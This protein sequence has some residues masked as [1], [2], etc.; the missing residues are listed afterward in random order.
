MLKWDAPEVVNGVTTYWDDTDIATAYLLP[1]TARFRLDDEGNPVFKFMKYKF[2]IDRADGKKGGGF[3]VCDVAF[4]VTDA[5][6]EALREPLQERVEARWRQAGHE[7]GA[8]AVRFGELNYLR[9]T[10]SVT[11]LDSGGALVEKIHNPASPSLYGDMILPITV[12]LSPEGATLLESALQEKGGIVQVA[13]DIWTPVK[14]PPVTAHVWFTAS[15]FSTFHQHID[16]EENFCSEDDYTETITDL[17]MQSDSGGVTIDPGTVTDQKIIGAVTDWAW[18]ALADAT[19]RM[20]LGD[21]P[22]QNPEEIRKLYTEQD[23]ENID[24]TVMTTRLA[25]FS[26]TFTQGQVMEWNP[27]PRGTIP[28]ITSMKGPDG[29]P[30]KWEDFATT[31]DLDD[32]FFRTMTVKTHVNADFEKLPLHSVEVKIEYDNAG[33]R[34]VEEYA[35]TGPDEI[36]TFTSFVANNDRR[37]TYTY[38]VNYKGEAQTFTSEPKVV[39]DPSL[40]INVG[41]IGILNLDIK[42]G[43]LNFDQVKSA[44]VELWYEDNGVPRMETAVTLDREHPTAN[45]TKV[46]F[47]PRRQPVHYQV[48]YF[49]ADGRE[50]EGG[51]RT[52][53]STELRINDPFGS[54]RTVQVRG[55]GDFENHID[56]IFLDLSYVDQVN[57]F[58]QTKS[59]TLTK[60]STFEDWMFPAILA[61]GGT[62]TYSGNIRFRDGTVEAIP[63]TPVEGTT[64]MVGDVVL[65]QPISVMADLVDWAVTKL[66]KVTLHHVEEKLDETE[67]LVFKDG[68]PTPL[69]WQ[70]PFK[71]KT[72]KAYSWKATYFKADGSNASIEGT[73]V[74]DET[75]VLPA[76]A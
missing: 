14:L 7:G 13:Y 60:T 45:W 18:S 1:K 33:D 24:M 2:P 10:A 59:V 28:N 17:V 31:V 25:N 39:N 61:D 73:D 62:L 11:V 27:Q 55:F 63:S 32:P 29:E 26:R 67:D 48:K 21:V 66:V 40:I 3:L 16:V 56:A 54:T 74:T 23:F 42:P 35:L 43:D 69:A 50:F 46:I 9:G 76:Q 37:Y 57:D 6:E 38:Q 64:V 72:K 71:D 68:T 34:K 53:A 44:Q 8:P 70:M 52:T 75:L 19:T 5:E 65:F 49:M 36:G 20:V 30:Y 4:G 41:D 47:Q 22:V 15:K 58:T 12:E 51:E